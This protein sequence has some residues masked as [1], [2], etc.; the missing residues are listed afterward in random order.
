VLLASVL[1]S[2][3]IIGVTAG[4]AQA[5]MPTLTISATA[6]AVTVAGTPQAGGVN[7]ITK[8][9]GVKEAGILLIHIRSGSTGAEVFSFLSA[10]HGGGTANEAS[11][12]GSIVFD[13]EAPSG[14]GSEAQTTLE[15]GEYIVLVTGEKGPNG[16]HSTFAVAA[17]PVNPAL[18]AAAAKIRAIDFGFKGAS[19]IKTGEVVGF[20]N[21]GFLVHMNFAFPVK[22]KKAAAKVMAALRSGHEK[23]LEK[24]IAGPPVS[25]AGPVSHGAYQQET[26]SAKPGF[27]VEVCFMET[28]DGRPHT[29]LGMERILR[30]TK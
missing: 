8:S 4:S 1:G 20:E 16:I 22:S 3:S 15:A 2:A 14:K 12:F 21:E 9:T 10:H 6:S 24:L 17:S 5:A 27:Y 18:P 26:I 11:K 30:I 7:I 19:T 28:Q 23:G 25:F 13:N 29:K